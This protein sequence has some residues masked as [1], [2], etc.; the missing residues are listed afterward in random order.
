MAQNIKNLSKSETRLLSILS[1]AGKNVFTFDDAKKV[2]AGE[3]SRT[4]QALYILAE[5]GWIKN[6][7]RGKYLIV[8]LEGIARGTWS[9]EAFVIAANLVDPY[10]ISYWSALNYY[11]YTEQIPRTIFVQTTKRKFKAETEVLGIPYKFVTVKSHKFFGT[12]NIWFGNKKVVITD[13]EKTIVDCLD[14][15]EYCGGIVEAA[16]GLA[17]AFDDKIDLKKLTQYAR[18]MDNRAIFKRLGYLSEALELPV[19]DY[20]SQWQ[21]MVSPGYAILDPL[22]ARTGK[23][24]SRWHIQANV[25]KANLTEWRTH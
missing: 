2:L 9:E 21:R 3:R 1:A 11:G 8:P 17:N 10:T 15:P 14:H 7:E 24:N 12:A 22:S 19:K 4:K 25:S 13:K 6:L 23:Y 18:K 20:P 5:K 16:K